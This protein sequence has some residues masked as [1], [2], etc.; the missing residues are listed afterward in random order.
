MK[1]FLPRINSEALHSKTIRKYSVFTCTKCGKRRRGEPGSVHVCCRYAMA[2]I[3]GV[4][5]K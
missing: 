5:T 1:N 4:I 3:P 2:E